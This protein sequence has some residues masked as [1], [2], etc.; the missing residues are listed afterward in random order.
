MSTKVKLTVYRFDMEKA[1]KHFREL[2]C[3]AYRPSPAER[4]V[5]T[6]DAHDDYVRADAINDYVGGLVP[7]DILVETDEDADVIV[8]QY[9]E[10]Q[11]ESIPHIRR[12]MRD[13]RKY[14]RD[15]LELI[16]RRE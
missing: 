12:A 5:I 15:R 4:R 10:T 3:C 2:Q 11:G 6:G 16:E 1:S 13:A 8:K 7:R 14:A 9:E